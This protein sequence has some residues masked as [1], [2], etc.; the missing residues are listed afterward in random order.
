MKHVTRRSLL[1]L[2]GASLAACS[3]VSRLTGHSLAPNT[4]LIIY[5][6]GDRDGED[7]NALGVTRSEAIAAALDG[8]PIDV[9]YSPGIQRNLD[10]AAP[11]AQARGM[12]ITRADPATIGRRI[13]RLSA[14]RSVVWVGNQ[15]NI[16]DIWE[17]LELEDPAPLEYGNLYIV[18]TD[19]AGT[20]SI[21]RRQ[22]DVD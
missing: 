22:V 16:R 7:L 10:T 20:V 9:I 2:A 18:T 21:E 14:G 17:A 4:R 1:V 13:A 19:G 12:E 3:R 11:L 15:G 8:L 5:R 6:H